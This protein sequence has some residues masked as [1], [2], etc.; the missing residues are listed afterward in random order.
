MGFLD[1]LFPKYCINCRK[2]GSYLCATC[3]SYI[4][5]VEQGT[6][7]VCQKQAIFSYTHPICTNKYTIDGVF[8]SVVY[9]GVVKKLVYTFKY[10]PYLTQLTGLLTDLFYE[11]LIQKEPFMKQVSSSSILVPIP[12]HPT[13]FRNRGYN[14]SKLLAE[15][16]EKKFGIKMVDGLERVKKTKTQ[17]GLTQTE[18][19]ENIKDAFVLKKQVVLPFKNQKQVFL[20]DDVSTS[21]AT[22]RE[23]AKVLKKAGVAKVWGIT[24]AHGL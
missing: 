15:G 19:Q 1:F 24:L 10:K 16:L 3:F 14:Q 18:R 11:G 21:G 7:V 12:L 6:C 5:F 20:V 9:T 22:L 8:S 13:R 17:V 2:F 23:A 4:S